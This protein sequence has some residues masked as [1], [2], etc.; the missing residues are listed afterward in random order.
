MKHST[1]PDYKNLM[2]HASDGAAVVS[3]ILAASCTE[4]KCRLLPPDALQ[5]WPAGPSKKATG[6]FRPMGENAPVYR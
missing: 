4:P 3:A 5:S 2:T 6:I 1:G